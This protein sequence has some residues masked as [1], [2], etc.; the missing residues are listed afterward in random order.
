MPLYFCI[1]ILKTK[2]MGKVNIE[3][4]HL[5][6]FSKNNKRKCPICNRYRKT[7]GKIYVRKPY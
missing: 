5:I 6:G 4:F 2:I 1:E 7:L 3:S